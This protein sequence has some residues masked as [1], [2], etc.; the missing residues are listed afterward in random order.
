MG[1]GQVNPLRAEGGEWHDAHSVVT[2]YITI[3]RSL[4]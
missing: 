1:G 3:W 2:L 4:I